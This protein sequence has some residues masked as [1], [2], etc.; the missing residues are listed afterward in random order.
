MSPDRLQEFLVVDH[1]DSAIASPGTA[2]VPVCAAPSGGELSADGAASATAG[3]SSGELP[4]QRLTLPVF[5]G[6]GNVFVVQEF[7]GECKECGFDLG[8]RCVE[9]LTTVVH[10]VDAPACEPVMQL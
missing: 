1:V 3:N 4:L 5:E 9:E 6:F 10:P 8:G 2:A 7:A